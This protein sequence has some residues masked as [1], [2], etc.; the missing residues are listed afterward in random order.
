MAE[1]RRSP[2]VPLN[3]AVEFSTEDLDLVVRVDGIGKDLSLGGMFIRT[4]FPSHFGEHIV[5]YLT[6]PG[7][8]HKMALPAGVRWG[9]DTAIR[10]PNTAWSD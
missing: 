8:K 9:R 4:D 7:W 6:L 5:V 2:R 1:L 3:H 10:S